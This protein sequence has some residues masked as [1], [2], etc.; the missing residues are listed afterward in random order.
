MNK[1]K[2]IGTIGPSSNNKEI[3]AE[4]VRSG[5]RIARL[6][7]SH[8][9][10]EVHKKN[11]EM[12]KE[13]REELGIP[14][15]ILMDT[16]GPEI[17]TRNFIDGIATLKTGEYV[18]LSPAEFDGNSERI[19]VTYGSLHTDVEIGGAILIDD[20]LIELQV[21]E[22]NGMDVRCLIKNG[23]DVKNHKGVNVPNIHLN[24]P[25]LTAKDEADLIFGVENDIDF[26]AAS[27]VRTAADVEVIRKHLIA[28]GGKH[29]Q[30]ISKIENQEGVNNIKEIVDASDGIMVARGDLG[31]ETP[32]ELIPEVQ[33]HIV[34][35]C[36]EM[37]KPVIIATQM[38]DSM[39]KNPRPTRAEVSDVANAIWDGA[40]AIMLS[41]ESAAGAYPVESVRMMKRIAI[42]TEK[43]VRDRAKPHRTLYDK[44]TSVTNAVSFATVTT[45]EYLNAKAIICPTYE[46]HTARMMSKF[47]P[48]SM[49]IAT[50]SNPKIQRIM[51]LYWGVEPILVKQETSSEILFY[52][53]VATIKAM[54]IAQEGDLVVITA[55]IPLGISGNTNLM[56]VQEVE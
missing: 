38:L 15:A 30:I 19:S 34:D 2:I 55:G 39:I 28:H 33:K 6:N 36:N 42:Q 26:V 12:I 9:D 7:L 49:I 41:G 31:V 54:G 56:K 52:K 27:F 46:G 47:K 53:S 32:P 24:L 4:L 14:V 35:I 40:D 8:G 3:F 22:I 11:I 10:Q 48:N 1:T 16:R 44:G 25:I 21:T 13:V 43:S 17:R 51:Q 37:E 20:G 45:A 50:T 5:L 18:T 23:G 29:V